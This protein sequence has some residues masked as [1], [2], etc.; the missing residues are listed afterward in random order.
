MGAG[1]LSM[2]VRP[3]DPLANAKVANSPFSIDNLAKGLAAL[4]GRVG[5]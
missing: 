1:H 3:R 5:P 4:Y 2:V